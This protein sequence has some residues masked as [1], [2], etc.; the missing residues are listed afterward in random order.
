[1]YSPDFLDADIRRRNEAIGKPRNL[2]PI[3]YDGTPQ[4]AKPPPLHTII[5]APEAHEPHERQG[6]VESL[7]MEE[8]RD[9]KAAIILPGGGRRDPAV[10]EFPLVGQRRLHKAARAT[11][12]HFNYKRK[13]VAKVVEYFRKAYGE[14]KLYKKEIGMRCREATE[15][16]IF[17]YVKNYR[18][19][20]HILRDQH[21]GNDGRRIVGSEDPDN[22]SVRTVANIQT[23]KPQETTRKAQKPLKAP[24]NNASGGFVSTDDEGANRYYTNFQKRMLAMKELAPMVKELGVLKDPSKDPTTQVTEHLLEGIDAAIESVIEGSGSPKLEQAVDNCDTLNRLEKLSILFECIFVDSPS[25]NKNIRDSAKELLIIFR[26]MHG[27][28]FLHKSPE[29]QSCRRF[30]RYLRSVIESTV[31]KFNG[32]IEAYNQLDFNVIKLPLIEKSLIESEI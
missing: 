3:G 2:L 6:M 19:N 31:K 13:T 17:K 28:T 23:S 18:P 24:S 1:M 12:E 15:S 14:K 27:L 32:E 21:F 5:S 8:V 20:K 26:K 4:N 16:D 25:M 22:S 10:K 30:C 9:D 11:Y 7:V 29:K